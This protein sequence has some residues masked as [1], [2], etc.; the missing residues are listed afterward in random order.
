VPPDTLVTKDGKDLRIVSSPSC[1]P[2]GNCAVGV[3]TLSVDGTAPAGTASVGHGADYVASTMVYVDLT[4][5]D[6]TAGLERT[7]LSNDGVRWR[8]MAGGSLL[9]DLADASAGGRPGTGTRTLHVR[10]TDRAGNECRI[11]REILVDPSRVSRLG[12]VDRFAT[13]AAI[14]RATFSSGVP[15]AY[16]AVATDFPDA[17]AGAAAAGKTGGPVLLTRTRG[18]LDDRTAAELTRLKPNRIVILGGTGAVSADTATHASPQV[19]M[20]AELPWAPEYFRWSNLDHL[21][22]DTAGIAMASYPW[23]DEYNPVTIAQVA[24]SNYSEW[25]TTHE[26]ARWATFIRHVEWLVANQ[27]ADG[28]WLYRFPFGGQPVPWWSAM[29]QGQ[30]ISALARAYRVTGDARYAS[31]AA[32]SLITFSRLQSDRGVT[33]VDAG[34]R[35]YEE[36]M[37]PYSAHTLNGFMFALV[38]LW[39]YAV[40]FGD[41]TSSRLFSDGIRTLQDELHRFDTGSWSCYS[42]P[43]L[44]R[45]HRASDAYHRLHIGQL[46]YLHQL[47]GIQT[48]A[49][50]AARWQGYLTGRT[51]ATV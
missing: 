43:D 39:E 40:T 37:P 16:I 38:G 46:R 35:W 17:L 12:G 48:F 15:V 20:G 42:L 36:Y 24:V 11:S 7:E 18:L 2:A 23:G 34:Y 27:T 32:R 21:G 3:I 45:C 25:L 4:A 5:S 33:A 8:T 50:F 49:S 6:A 22:R 30:A 41:A 26:P 51:A 10:W 19:G 47:T 14:A 31:A 29:A 9:W 44:T 1:D 28:L 13:A